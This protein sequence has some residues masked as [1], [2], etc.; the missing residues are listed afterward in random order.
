MQEEVELD[1]AFNI[2]KGAKVKMGK[3]YGKVTG[4]ETVMGKPGVEVT[5]DGGKKGRFQMSAFAGLHMDRKAD[6]VIIEEVE[7]DGKD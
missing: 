1:E 2:P 7:L 3:S 5:W 6:Y 4:I